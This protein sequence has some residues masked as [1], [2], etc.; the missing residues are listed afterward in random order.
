M[1]PIRMSADEMLA[2]ARE[3]EQAYIDREP[4]ADAK[5]IR[6]YDELL[7]APGLIM[8]QEPYRNATVIFNRLLTNVGV[9]NPN[10]FDKMKYVLPV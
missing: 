8:A 5:I 7:A 10:I 6:L 4:D 2:K 9:R 3:L 1:L